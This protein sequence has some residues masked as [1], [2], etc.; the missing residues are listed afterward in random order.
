[1]RDQFI[2]FRRKASKY[3]GP[4]AYGLI[5]A[6]VCCMLIPKFGVFIK[7]YF[8][9]ALIPY[10][11]ILG[12]YCFKI[13]I[14]AV[15]VALFMDTDQQTTAEQA[16]TDAI[17][18]TDPDLYIKYEISGFRTYVGGGSSGYFSNSFT[19]RLMTDKNGLAQIYH[20]KEKIEEVWLSFPKI[21][22]IL[23]A[24]ML[25][26]SFLSVINDII[27]Y[28][29]TL[30]SIMFPVGIIMMIVAYYPVLITWGISL[31]LI[32]LTYIT[33]R[34]TPTGFE[35]AA[36]PSTTWIIIIIG[37]AAIFGIQRLFKPVYKRNEYSKNWREEYRKNKVGKWGK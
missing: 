11:D 36:V 19:R 16:E 22:F 26:L 32:V 13:G 20:K 27:I 4:V 15:I 8:F 12:G 31:S 29:M 9:N 25:V 37:I 33:G 5:I 2:L 21:L 17:L 1:M 23:G 6:G 3:L 30:R 7:L 34:N 24:V 28:D 18:Q 35:W 14:P 10:T